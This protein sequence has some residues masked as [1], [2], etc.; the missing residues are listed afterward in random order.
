M[1]TESCFSLLKRELGATNPILAGKRLKTM[2]LSGL[3]LGITLKDFIPPL[4]I[5][6]RGF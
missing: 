3:R 6:A 5:K 4:D 1:D 2:S